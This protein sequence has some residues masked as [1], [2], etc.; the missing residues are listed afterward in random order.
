[1]LARTQP[2]ATAPNNFP[3]IDETTTAANVFTLPGN[4]RPS[5]QGEPAL[6]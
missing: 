3:R 4:R 6:K 2:T 1:L 5:T